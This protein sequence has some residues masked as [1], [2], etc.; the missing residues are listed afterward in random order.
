MALRPTAALGPLQDLLAHPPA[1]GRLA[2]AFGGAPGLRAL[3]PR[4]CTALY[5]FCR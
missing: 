4:L 2:A 3:A 5:I 1:L